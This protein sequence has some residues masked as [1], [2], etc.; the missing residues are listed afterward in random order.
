VFCTVDNTIK[1]CYY[2]HSSEERE[3][4]ARRE[5]ADDF[6]EMYLHKKF[7]IDFLLDLIS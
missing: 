1:P 3:T 7:P 5:Q 6:P 2:I 4:T